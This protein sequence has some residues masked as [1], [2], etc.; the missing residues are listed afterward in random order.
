MTITVY[1]HEV[2]PG[3]DVGMHFSATFALATTAAAQYHEAFRLMGGEP[4]GR[5]DIYEF[6]LT[7]PEISEL[8]AILNSPQAVFPVCLAR[9]RFVGSV[10]S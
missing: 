6:I 10:E 8:I 3:S 2:I 9:K 5:L 1:A 4:L 7:K